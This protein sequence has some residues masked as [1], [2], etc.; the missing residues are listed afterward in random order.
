MTIP[1]NR[2]VGQNRPKNPLFKWKWHIFT[3]YKGAGSDVCMNTCREL[4]CITLP[5]YCKHMCLR[6]WVVVCFPIVMKNSTL[7]RSLYNVLLVK[8][9]GLHS[10]L[11]EWS[12]A[13]RSAI[14]RG[15]EKSSVL[16]F[17]IKSGTNQTA[18]IY[19]EQ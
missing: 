13:L 9:L 5:I 18:N 1:C 19:N 16:K 4:N 17:D 11:N 15:R 2:Q 3:F 8:I 14:F 12:V 6:W 7:F 10:H